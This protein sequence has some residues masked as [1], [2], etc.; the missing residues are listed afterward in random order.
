[1]QSSEP[2]G[3]SWRTLVWDV[4]PVI[5]L[6]M[7]SL[8]TGD[9]RDDRGHGLEILAVL[10]LVLRRRWPLPTLVAVAGLVV[11][12]V[13]DSSSPWVLVGA[14]ALASYTVGDLVADRTR[15][16]ASVLAVAGFV[17]LGVVQGADVLASLVLPFVIAMPAWLAGDV[18]RGR[19]LEAAVRAAA[20]ER[21][22]QDAEE[23]VRSAAAEER[24]HMAREL[25]DVVAHG[26]SVMVIQA[27]AARQVLEA[28]PDRA[29]ESLLTVESTG[30]DVMAEL[31]RLLGVLN[32]DGE[33]TGLAPQPGIDQ[34]GALVERVHEAGLPASLRVEGTPT[35]L[36]TSLDVTAYRIVQEALTNALRYAHRAATLVL[37]AYEPTQLRLEIL[38]DGPNAAAEATEGSGRGLVGMEQRAALVG[39]RLTTGPRLGGGYAVRAWLPLEAALEPAPS[40]REP[41]HADELAPADDPAD[42][43]VSAP[44]PAIDL[45]AAP[46]PT[47][48]P[49][50]APAPVAAPKATLEPERT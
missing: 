28:S 33:A 50:R 6:V 36:P 49:A 47:N 48:V 7:Y 3:P 11:I 13:P 31:R 10:P 30:R 38:D 5:A 12:L 14:L 19:R 8:A 41:A 32:D 9:A 24:R 17:A 39:G 35:P 29:E 16:A 1:M 4:G 37:V 45:A 2:S 27:G 25:H 18:I 40:L 20:T 46:T 21:A 23:R 26:V 42:E 15:S 34:L 43:L 22:L 44:T